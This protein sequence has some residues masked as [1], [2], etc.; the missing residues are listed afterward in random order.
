[1]RQHPQELNSNLTR[2]ETR[3]QRTLPPAKSCQRPGPNRGRGALGRWDRDSACA[4]SGIWVLS[5][6]L[7]CGRD[8][9]GVEEPHCLKG[10][11][12]LHSTS[13]DPFVLMDEAAQNVASS[14]AH[15]TRAP[16]PRASSASGEEWCRGR[17]G[18]D[19][20]PYSTAGFSG[21]LISHELDP[22]LSASARPLRPP[23]PCS[24]RHRGDRCDR[25]PR[26]V[27]PKR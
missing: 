27:G 3:E 16:R 15:R 9:L 11:E 23:A 7:G 17:V 13:R 5:F 25:G 19:E 4:G 20:E 14:H 2:A 18:G 22:I 8:C 10:T 12:T 26:G 24:G 21:Q 1:M 6:G